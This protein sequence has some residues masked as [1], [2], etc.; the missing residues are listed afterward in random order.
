[1]GD[2]RMDKQLIDDAT[3][4]CEA[5][6]IMDRQFIEETNKISYGQAL[7]GMKSEYPTGDELDAFLNYKRDRY[8][9]LRHMQKKEEKNDIS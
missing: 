2:I 1:M 5:K 8:I 9:S 3:V 7:D 4:I 6:K